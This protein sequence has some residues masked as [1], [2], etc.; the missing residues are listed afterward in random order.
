[1]KPAHKTVYNVRHT[2]IFS[3]IAETALQGALVLGKRERL[4]LGDNILGLY[5]SIFDH[6]ESRPEK[7]SHS[8]K[9]AK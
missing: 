9:N 2:T 1:M 3:A 5:T 4:E 7:V 6:C 8:L